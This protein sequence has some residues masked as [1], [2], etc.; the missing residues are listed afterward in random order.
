MLRP[1]LADGVDLLR[2]VPAERFLE[3]AE[4]CAKDP[5][6]MPEVPAEVVSVKARM[7]DA[8]ASELA[9]AYRETVKQTR[10]GLY[11]S[12]ALLFRQ[13]LNDLSFIQTLR[14]NA[15]QVTVYQDELGRKTT[16]TYDAAED[17]KQITRPDGST[18]SFE[19]DSTFHHVT[20][21]TDSLNRITTY[22]YNAFGD[23][24]SSRLSGR[25]GFLK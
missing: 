11:A 4:Q 3:L 24:I 2:L 19:Y 5:W 13:S 21:R 1:D 20:K 12:G 25:S 9:A 6:P 16:F 22:T 8:I 10:Y 14:D 18:V 17:L 15:D 7:K 23:E